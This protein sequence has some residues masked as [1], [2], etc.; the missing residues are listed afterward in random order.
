MRVYCILVLLFLA[1]AAYGSVSVL[2]TSC[3]TDVQ[4]PEFEAFWS[5]SSQLD[6][7]AQPVKRPSGCSIH[8]FLRN[9]GPQPLEIQDVT[10]N[11]ISLVKAVAFSEQ[12][13]MR[14]AVY[15]ASIYF[16]N[17]PKDAL[18]AAGEPVWWRVE[19]NPIPPNSVSE[20]VVR[21]RR[22]PIGKTLTIGLDALKIP[23]QVKSDQPRIE[24]ISFSPS[25]NQVYLCITKAPTKVL[26]DGREIKFT[27]KTDTNLDITPVVCKLDKPLAKASFH[28]FTGVFQDGSA[29]SAGIRAWSGEMCFGIWGSKPG[30][31]GDTELARS[32]INEIAE[33]SINTQMEMVASDA[34]SSFMQSDEGL[35]ML[36]SLGIRRMVSDPGKGKVKSPFAY[37]LLDEPDVGDFKVQGVEPGK[38]VGCLAQGLVQRSAEFRKADP[39]TP[40]FL[41]LDMTFKPDNWYTYGQLPDIFAADPY[42]QERLCQSYWHRPGRLSLYTKAT[43]IYAVGTVS[44]EASSPKPMHLLLNSVRHTEPDRVFRFATPEEKRIETYYALASGVKGLSYWWYTPAGQCYGCGGP[45]PEAV[46]LWR[47]IGLLGAELRTIGPLVTRSCPASL[48][49]KTS[50]MLWVRSL[51]AGQDSLLLLCV[52]DNYANDRLGTVIHP[53]EKAFIEVEVP[54]WLKATQAFEVN[55]KGTQDIQF[56]RTGSKAR[57]ELGHVDVTRLIVITSD[58]NLRDSLQKYYDSHLAANVARLTAAPAP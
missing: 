9:D 43:Y 10:L 4:H 1:A 5:D 56:S 57:I 34:V 26:I 44:R 51:L 14:K 18:I 3:R 17:L 6:W 32:Y 33:H 58:S 27:A 29:A 25:L 23:V 35:K 16:S 11:G 37:F 7:G 40:Q 15:P 42:Y 49:I 39:L 20:I 53:L 45:E 36:D 48:P 55:F 28:A 24:S 52:N 12:R 19:P 22:A 46:A 2:G 31:E 54:S 30:K 21:L 50:P 41:N 38:Q 8:V 47:E 13:K